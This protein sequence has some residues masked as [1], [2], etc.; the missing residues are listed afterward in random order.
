M[1]Q[2]NDSFNEYDKKYEIL[3]NG[4]GEI[5][6]I[7]GNRQDEPENPRIIYDGGDSV[8]LYRN[9]E[10]S[11]FLTNVAEDAR[12]PIQYVN[13]ITI[14]EIQGDEVIREYIAPVR[15]I[16]DMKDILN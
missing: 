1:T 16:K 12:Q 11:I 9:R 14:A 5:L 13:K 2:T 8:L 15:L 10:S 6:I 4:A 3:K 7:I